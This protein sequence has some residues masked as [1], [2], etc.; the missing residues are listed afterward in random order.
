ML[1]H[2]LCAGRSERRK[3]VVEVREGAE[4]LEQDE[5]RLAELCKRMRDK[6]QARRA[7][8]LRAD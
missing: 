6:I 5:L 1:R 2:D 4:E 3:G 7:D 8:I